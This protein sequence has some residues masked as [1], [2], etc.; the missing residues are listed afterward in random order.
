MKPSLHTALSMMMVWPLL[1]AAN[2]TTDQIKQL[3]SHKMPAFNTPYPHESAVRKAVTSDFQFVLFM[4]GHCMACRRFYPVLQHVSQETGLAI[5]SYT[6]DGYSITPGEHAIPAPASVLH[7]FF[8]EHYR[9]ITPTVFLVNVNTL[10]VYPLV[11]G[12]ATYQ[13]LLRRVSQM[14]AIA[15]RR[16]HHEH[17]SHGKNH[18]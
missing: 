2:Q 7:T 14:L 12:E 1:G 6:L 13:Q 17:D 10:D 15:G 4:Q 11:Q 16:D 8:G 3:E 18:R 9:V 5:F